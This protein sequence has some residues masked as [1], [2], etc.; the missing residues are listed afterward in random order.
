MQRQMVRILRDLHVRE[1]A[2][3]SQRFLHGLRRRRRFD[4][5]LMAVR[6]RVLR[7]DGFD[8]HEPRRLVF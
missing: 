6:T 1:E 8:H 2:F 4:D 3:A 7:A 5:A